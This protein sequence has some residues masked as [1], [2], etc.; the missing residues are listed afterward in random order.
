MMLIYA[1]S[2]EDALAYGTDEDVDTLARQL[3]KAGLITNDERKS[4]RFFGGAKATAAILIG[5]VTVKVHSN[6]DNFTTFLDVLKKDKETYGHILAKM[7][8]KGVFV[9]MMIIEGLSHS[10]LTHKC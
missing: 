2:L 1:P 4:F 10:G 8:E 9:I 7:E 3:V 6:S 5:M